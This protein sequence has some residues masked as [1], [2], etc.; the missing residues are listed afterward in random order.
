MKFKVIA[1]KSH[2]IRG[3]NGRPVNPFLIRN[4]FDPDLRCTVERR[5]WDEIEAQS[6]KELRRLFD[7]AGSAT[8]GFRLVHIERI[9]S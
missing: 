5:T 2:G 7:E 8:A 1:E 4:I 9:D 6:E 3:A